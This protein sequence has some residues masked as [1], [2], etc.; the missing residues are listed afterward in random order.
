M[1]VLCLVVLAASTISGYAGS[2]CPDT[3]VGV[4]LVVLGILLFAV[5]G[6]LAVVAAAGEDPVWTDVR[7]WGDD[8]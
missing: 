1:S 6:V 2:T 8:Q 5:G 3:A 4:G 7:P